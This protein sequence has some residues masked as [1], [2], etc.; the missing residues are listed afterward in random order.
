MTTGTVRWFNAEKG[1]RFISPDDVS[2]DGF[3]H[4]SAVQ[5]AGPSTLAD[6]QGVAHELQAGRGGKLAAD[7]ISLVK[8]GRFDQAWDRLARSWQPWA[9]PA[10]GGAANDNWGLAIAT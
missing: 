3:V 10:R 2:A 4:I 7:N 6:G 8:S 5:L 9:P 1:I